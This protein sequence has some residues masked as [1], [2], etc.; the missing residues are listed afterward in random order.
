MTTTEI[1]P[2]RPPV[3]PAEPSRLW[4][5]TADPDKTVPTVEVD[6]RGPLAFG[7]AVGG[8]VALVGALA[9]CLYYRSAGDAQGTDLALALAS[10]AF[11]TSLLAGHTHQ[12]ARVVRRRP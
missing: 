3:V 7:I 11:L 8:F 12:Q 6:T 4:R 1:A 5:P 10:V 2:D 9:A